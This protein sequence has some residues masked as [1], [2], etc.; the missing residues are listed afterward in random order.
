MIGNDV[1]DILQSRVESNW[2]RPGFIHK[3]FTNNEQLL[4]ADAPEAEIMVWLLW[5]MKEAAYKIY[6]R[7]TKIREYIPKQLE[8]KLLL[9]TNQ[10]TNGIVACKNKVYYTSSVVAN[11][12]VHTIAVGRFDDLDKVIDIENK[13]IIKNQYGIPYLLNAQNKLQDV[14][15]S[16]HGR[17]EKVV[18]LKS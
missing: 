8:C 6:N 10:Y 4:I 18:T 9:K 17:I 1:V 3:L 12:Y 14:S 7:E 11:N 2:Q 5:S 16:H 13:S 15:I